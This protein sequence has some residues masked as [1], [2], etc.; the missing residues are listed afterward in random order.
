MEKPNSNISNILNPQRIGGLGWCFFSEK[1]GLFKF[2]KM[3][4][5]GAVLS[6]RILGEMIYP[7]DEHIFQ[8]D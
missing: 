8:T 2:K 7:F 5:F 3:C 4:V 6:P 1:S